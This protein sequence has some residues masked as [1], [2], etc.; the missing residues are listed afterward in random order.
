MATWEV[1]ARFY[2]AP[3]SDRKGRGGLADA[4]AVA[5]ITLAVVL[6][7]TLWMIRGAPQVAQLLAP[8]SASWGALEAP[9]SVRAHAAFTFR[10]PATPALQAKYVVSFG[11]FAR[12][13]S[14][15]ARARVIRSK[16]YIASVVRAGSAYLVVSRPYASLDAAEFWSGIFS[17]IGLPVRAITQREAAR[18]LFGFHL[19]ALIGQ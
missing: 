12:R 2:S 10:S 11:R 3:A 9:A 5:G 13:E 1:G 8:A 7:A 17:E 19:P 14:A 18:G 6:T 16:G 15:N 4:A